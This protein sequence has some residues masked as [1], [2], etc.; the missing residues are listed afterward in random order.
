M[1]YLK[2]RLLTVS[3]LVGLMLCSGITF[4]QPKK[5]FPMNLKKFPLTDFYN[6]SSTFA[7][8]GKPGDLIRSEKFDGYVVP[9]GV[10]AT[11][12]LYGTKT[13]KGD[14]AVSSGVVLIPPG[15]APKGGWPVIAWA[16]GTSG[17]NRKC[18]ISLTAM[19]FAMYRIPNAHLKNGYAVVATDYAGLGSDSAVAYMDRIGNAWDVIYS[20]KAAQKAVPSLGR[21]WLAIGHSAGA[22][23]MGGVAELQAD[24]NDPSYLGIVS[25]SGLGNARDPMVFISKDNPVLAFFICVSV[26]ARYPAFE[27]TDVLTD[28]GLEL[29]EQVKSKCQGPG[30]GP[31]GPSPIKGSEALKKDWDLNPYI[32]K[33][34]KMDESGQERYKGPAL[35]LI[36]EM[37]TPHTMKNDPAV[38]KRMCQQEVD[39]LLKIISGA[40]HVSLLGLAIEDQTKWIA[41]RF[42][43]KEYPCNC[44]TI[45]KK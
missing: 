12:I 32:D 37:E 39:V 21:R 6:T 28:K 20:V 24:I 16:H 18:A 31:P 25:L 40:N 27:Y 4:A 36:G 41:D 35:V 45:L 8:N 1:K 9:P 30:F 15:E 26:K 17:A 23:T 10:T 5:G 7:K 29:F 34:F 3:F 14:V 19:G 2:Y 13:S 11:R 38:A 22:H 33:Y 42:A 43:G 44:E